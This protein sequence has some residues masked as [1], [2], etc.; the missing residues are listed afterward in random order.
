MVA[1]DA[2]AQPLL[3]MIDQKDLEKRHQEAQRE[4]KRVQRELRRKAKDLALAA[5]LG[6]QG[7]LYR[8]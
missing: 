3:M 4:I 7:P 6:G 1:Q 8:F 2:N 5:D